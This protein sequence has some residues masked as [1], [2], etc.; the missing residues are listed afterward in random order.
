MFVGPCI[1]AYDKFEDVDVA[2]PAAFVAVT[3]KRYR[4]FTF[5]ATSDV[6]TEYVYVLL[7][8]DEGFV[9]TPVE[10]SLNEDPPSDDHWN[11]Y[12]KDVGDCDQK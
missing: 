11:L 10:I 1:S 3:E 7:D 8:P 9:A 12:D 2:P 5:A 6:G 4:L